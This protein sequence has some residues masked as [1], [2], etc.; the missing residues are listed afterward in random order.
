M[1]L[2]VGGIVSVH[3]RSIGP[4]TLCTLENM[5]VMCRGRRNG[6]ESRDQH[7]SSQHADIYY[8]YMHALARC[9]NVRSYRWTVLRLSHTF[10]E[11]IGNSPLELTNT[12]LLDLG[13]AFVRIQRWKG[14]LEMEN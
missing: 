2:Q 4:A 12:S 10:I 5:T 3:R 6:C 13:K 1:R 11:R 9:P 14:A 7:L 8:A